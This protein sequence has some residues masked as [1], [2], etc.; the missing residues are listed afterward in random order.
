MHPE[1]DAAAVAVR[2]NAAVSLHERKMEDNDAGGH[3]PRGLDS[4]V[5]TIGQ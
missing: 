2:N 3:P 1:T 5:A 4:L